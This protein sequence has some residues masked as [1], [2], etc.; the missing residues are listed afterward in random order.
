MIDTSRSA[1]P[2][3]GFTDS[4]GHSS[5][6]EYGMSLRDWFAGQALSGIYASQWFSDHTAGNGGAGAALSAY[7]AADAM[8]KARGK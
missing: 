2:L 3:P 4:N 8:M 1:F 5:Y 6:P 7:G